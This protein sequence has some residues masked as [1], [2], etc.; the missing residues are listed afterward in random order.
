MDKVQ[1]EI[2]A[3][4]DALGGVPKEEPKEPEKKEPEKNEEVEEKVTEQKEEEKD[5]GGEKTE[6][7]ADTDT[8]R[9]EEPE[10]DEKDKT[11]AELRAQIDKLSG[12]KEEPKKEEEKKEE[13]EKKAEFKEE[14]LKLDSHDFIG[15][16]DPDDIVRDKESFNKLLNSVYAKGVSD[17]KKIAT[18]GV[19]LS[20]PEIVRHNITLQNT[21]REV[22]EKF[23]KDNSDLTGFKKVVAAVFEEVA[24]EN[25]GK[26]YTEIMDL[27]APE[28]RKRLGLAKAAKKEEKEKAPRLPEKKGGSRQSPSKPDTSSLQSEIE[29]MNKTIGRY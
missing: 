27:V 6:E 15:D 10:V 24:A 22:S 1:G 18:E 25:P 3:M 13:P 16:D 17:A 28:A 14:P 5:D 2:N 21:L 7:N 8:G 4:L 9:K 26:K 29:E 12:G 19:L 23:Y 11:I 20:I